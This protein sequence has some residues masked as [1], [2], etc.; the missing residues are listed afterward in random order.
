MAITINGTGSITGLTAGG[1]PDGSITSADL[2]SG[3]I[4]A[5][6]L[7]TGSILQ[8]VQEVKTSGAT[9]ATQNTWAAIP[10]FSAS[11]TPTATS[12]NVLILIQANVGTS[13]QYG[14]V[15]MRLTGTTSTAVGDAT[16]GWE[17]TAT[18]SPRSAD[19]GY[20]QIPAVIS[21]LDSPATTSQVTYGVEWTNS[22]GGVAINR[23]YNLP[24][25]Y[26]GNTISTIT[27]MEVAG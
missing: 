17:T 11:I 26:S 10:G 21:F 24:D 1:L 20:S 15:H 27:L 12:S 23:S 18:V 7:P 8:V 4:T 9:Y 22:S 13:D 3:A 19:S 16:T 6:A 2:A 5:G 25:T 14:R